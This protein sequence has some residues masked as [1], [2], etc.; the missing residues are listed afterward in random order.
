[1]IFLLIKLEQELAK[2]SGLKEAL[3]EMG[4]S[5]WQGKSRK[6][7]SRTWTSDA[8]KRFLGWYKKSWRGY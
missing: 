5:L 8:R 3:K 6:K 1:M 7:I 4:A 2:V